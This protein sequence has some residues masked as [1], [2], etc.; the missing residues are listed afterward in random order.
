MGLG[1]IVGT[2]VAGLGLVGVGFAGIAGQDDTTRD[3]AGAIVEGGDLGA[4]RIRVGDCMGGG[5]GDLVE[6]VDGVPCDQLH[7]FEVYHAFNV[8]E[9]ADGYPGDAAIED[10]AFTGCYD[11]FAPFVGETYEQSLYGI[12]TLAPTEESW[13][14]LDDREVLCLIGFY[15]GS[16]KTGSARGT[17]I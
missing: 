9:G 15:D 1:K 16:K 4:F 7:E 14:E 3:E 8:P 12:N 11:A 13:D 2:T 10:A 5:L 6:S 17:G